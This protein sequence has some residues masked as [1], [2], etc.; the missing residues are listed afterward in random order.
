MPG[1]PEETEPMSHGPSSEG[2]SAE[3]NLTPLLDLVLQLLMFF[4]LCANFKQ[5]LGNN[6]LVDLAYSESAKPTADTTTEDTGKDIIYVNLRRYVP[7]DYP[8]MSEQD[9]REAENFFKQPPKALTDV[10]QK[11]LLETDPL[12]QLSGQVPALWCPRFA[13]EN[14]LVRRPITMDEFK[15]WL[16]KSVELNNANNAKQAE[17]ARKNGTTPTPPNEIIVNIRA[18]EGI[19]WEHFFRVRDY[20]TEYGLRVV[21]TVYRPTKKSDQ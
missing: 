18:E 7:K 10:D 6:P 8:D 15:A 4:V 13:F 1:R 19:H 21:I 16:K 14:P 5:N 12:F 9:R 2:S 11:T 20:C 3:P 17:D